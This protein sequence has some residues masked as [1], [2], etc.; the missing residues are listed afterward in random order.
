MLHPMMEGRAGNHHGLRNIGGLWIEEGR[1]DAVETR[2]WEIWRE[3]RMEKPILQE[4]TSISLGWVR[5]TSLLEEFQQ[6]I[7]ESIFLMLLLEQVL[8]V[9]FTNFSIHLF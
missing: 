2:C 5:V 9:M 1:V 4:N 6:T 8:F 3:K 7:N